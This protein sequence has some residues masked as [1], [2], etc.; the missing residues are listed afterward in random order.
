MIDR[1]RMHVMLFP[2]LY[3]AL[4]EQSLYVYIRTQRICWATNEIWTSEI[5]RS[6]TAVSV[7]S[8]IDASPPCCLA[9]LRTD[10]GRSLSCIKGQEGGGISNKKTS[11]EVVS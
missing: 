11:L 9:T 2:P 1:V 5:K 7:K 3:L 8:S 6:S 4:R 10:D